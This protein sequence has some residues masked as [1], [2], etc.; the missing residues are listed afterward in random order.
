MQMGAANSFPIYPNQQLMNYLPYTGTVNAPR[1]SMRMPNSVPYY[2]PQYPVISGE[3]PI[4]TDEL[5]MSM[6]M[7][8]DAIPQQVNDFSQLDLLQANNTT[9]SGD[10][11]N[12]TLSDCSGS[13]LSQSNSDREAPSIMT[14]QMNNLDSSRPPEGI[15]TQS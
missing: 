1:A 12:G 9:L 8:F 6:A 4:G 2:P 5:S 7:P 11:I 10:H 13:D 14:L 15:V 3:Y